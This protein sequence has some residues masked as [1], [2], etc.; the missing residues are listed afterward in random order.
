M[1]RQGCPAG[2]RAACQQA[3]AGLSSCGATDLAPGPPGSPGCILLTGGLPE[4]HGG[5]SR[6][7]RCRWGRDQLSAPSQGRHSCKTVMMLCALCAEVPLKVM[8]LRQ[9]W[10]CPAVL[11]ASAAGGSMFSCST[12][13][14]KRQ[15]GHAVQPA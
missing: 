1:P 6:G 14:G 2:V 8:R 7:R 15:P 11:P 10:N 3:W 12:L 4:G 9:G 13:V 5:S